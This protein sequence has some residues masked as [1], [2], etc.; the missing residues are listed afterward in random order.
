MG[1][2]FGSSLMLILASTAEIHLTK[3]LW[4]DGQTAFQ[5]YIVDKYFIYVLVWV[6]FD[7]N[8]IMH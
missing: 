8:T 4:T 5:R 3:K 7:I 6:I 1:A 2:L